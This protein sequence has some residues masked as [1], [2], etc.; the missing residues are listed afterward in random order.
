MSTTTF[1]R[2]LCWRPAR[3]VDNPRND[4]FDRNGIVANYLSL[5]QNPIASKSVHSGSWPF[6]AYVF[7]P[8]ARAYPAPSSTHR[9]VHSASPCAFVPCVPPHTESVT[10]PLSA[11]PDW[12]Y[13][14]MIEAAADLPAA[15]PMP[16]M[17][18]TET[19]FRTVLRCEC[20]RQLVCFMSCLSTIID[21]IYAA[22]FN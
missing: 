20:S 17:I 16:A 14:P 21:G 15:V 12:S 10:M 11:M 7:L 13:F 19:S 18:K 5:Y 22:R 2:T 3:S 6:R 1:K 8:I 9:H 4:R